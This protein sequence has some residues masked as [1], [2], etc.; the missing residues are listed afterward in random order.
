MLS[1]VIIIWG[2][3]YVVGRLLSHSFPSIPGLEQQ[4]MSG[5]FYGF[6]RYFF[7]TL[8]MFFVIIY[9]KKTFTGVIEEINPIK[10]YLILSAFFSAI[11]VLAS[12]ASSE[13]IS[14]G[15]TSIIVNLC[16]VLVFLYGLI[17]L[18]EKLT[19]LKLMGFFLGV[20]GGSL[21]LFSSFNSSSGSSSIGVFLAIIGMVSWGTYS[22]LLYYMGGNDSYIIMTVKHGI[23]TLISIPIIFY[24]SIENNNEM[25]LVIDLWTIFG[26]IF[27]GIFATGIAYI[28]YF[29]AIESLGAPKASAFLFLIP[30]VSLLG[31][32][33]LGELPPII[34]LFG[35]IIALIGVFFIK[36]SKK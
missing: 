6:Y 7:R 25:V 12:H 15:T 23:S 14:S 2:I 34:S 3:N 30:F 31:D 5:T 4:H 32:T 33:L 19:L 35:G 8:T 22:I 18:R 1:L 28:L 17:F 21:F 26:F 11:F 24:V 36:I 20:I 13:Y 9:Q 29:K 16:P 10:Y 27:G